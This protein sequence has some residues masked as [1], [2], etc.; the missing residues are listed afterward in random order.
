M[1][2]ALPKALAICLLLAAIQLPVFRAQEPEAEPSEEIEAEAE[3]PE[4]RVPEGGKVLVGRID[5]EINL[6][7]SAYV[8]RLV[9]TAT[10]SEAAVLMIELNTFGGRVDAAVLI[11][12][13]LI[14]APMHTAVFINKRAI[15]AGALISLACNSIAISPGGTIGAATPITSGPGQEIPAAVEEKYLSYFRQE[16]RSTAETRG[17]D[18]DIAEAMVDAEKE[19]EGVSEKGKLLTLN[20]RTALELS[21]ADAEARSVSEALEALGLDGPTDE[22][23]RTWSE[24]LVAFLTSQAIAS[25]LVLGMMVLGYMELQTPGFGAF[26]IG[27]LICFLLLYFSHYLVNL[28]GSEELLLFSIGVILL[29]IELFAIPGFGLVGLAGALSIMASLVLLLM[30][31]DWSDFSFENPFSMAAVTQVL[32]TTL[33]GILAILLLMRFLPTVGG[34]TR[35]GRRLFLARGLES[36][37]GYESHE[38]VADELEGKTGEALTALRPSGKARIDGR[39]LNVETEGDFVDKGEGVRVLKSEPGRVVVRRS[40]RD[41]V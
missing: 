9:D 34:R 26:G 25:I 14:D 2:K 15:S 8:K 11:R 40:D 23:E 1:R 28:A 6:A 31:G 36:S 18:G 33:V 24:A 22:L 20:T 27:A 3:K 4:R 29:L 12:D 39:R 32:V 16:M 13:A 38:P 10:T 21:F 5:G 17:R 7:A 19:V 41:A 30:A 35:L 37:A